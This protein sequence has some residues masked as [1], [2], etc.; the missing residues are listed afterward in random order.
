MNLDI[1]LSKFFF[2]HSLVPEIILFYGL[3]CFNA[4]N[5]ACSIG[6]YALQIFSHILA[7]KEDHTGCH[8][9]C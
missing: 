5:M 7:A 3:L 9:N 6:Y 2:I 4:L 8:C 1:F